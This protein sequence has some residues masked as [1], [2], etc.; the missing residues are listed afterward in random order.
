MT[1]P[2][3][4][5]YEKEGIVNEVESKASPKLQMRK[6]LLV[7]YDRTSISW[8]F[9]FFHPCSRLTRKRRATWT[10]TVITSWALFLFMRRAHLHPM[11]PLLKIRILENHVFG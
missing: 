9:H 6:S 1:Y 4:I 7:A 10:T 8:K 5:A 3:N 2:C 11:T